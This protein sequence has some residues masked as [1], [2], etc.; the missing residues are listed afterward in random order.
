MPTPSSSHTAVSEI[1]ALIAEA[2]PFAIGL[3]REAGAILRSYQERGFDIVHKGTVDLVTDADKASEALIA[4]RIRERFPEHRLFGEEGARSDAGPD[5][6]FGWVIDPL[7]GTTNFAHGYPQFAVSLGLELHG[8][9]ILG[10]VYDPSRDELF[11]G[12]KGMGAT[13]NDVP[14]HVSGT[15]TVRQALL[16]TGFSYDLT[17]RTES[18]AL[19]TA[20]NNAAQGLRRDGAAALD[21]C[22]VACGRLDGYFERP[23]MSWDMGG[24]VVIVRE[25][26]GIVTALEDDDWRLERNEALVAGPQLIPEMRGLIVSTLAETR[27][28]R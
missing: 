16:A 20:F 26:G 1:D 17:Q 3:A 24:S 2:K 10:V 7:D 19:W 4:S 18:T 21:L 28:G 25:A 27:A 8:E 9:P 15:G 22:W 6:P 11:V 12:A 5:A 13:L 14:I 23:V